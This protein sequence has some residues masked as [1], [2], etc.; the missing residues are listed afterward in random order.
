MALLPSG[1]L[2]LPS[3]GLDPD[4]SSIAQ[5][6]ILTQSYPFVESNLNISSI[7][8]RSRFN[9]TMN[10]SMPFSLEK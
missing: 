8:Q 3:G 4:S 2:P 9:E 6:L 5:R 7:G 1:G 10:Q